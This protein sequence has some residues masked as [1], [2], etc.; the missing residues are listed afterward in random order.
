[1]LKNLALSIG[2]F[3]FCLVILEGV[4][5]FLYEE[6]WTGGQCLNC[7]HNHRD[8]TYGFV[9]PTNR[10]MEAKRVCD[11]GKVCYDVKYTY[12][13]FGRRIVG[14]EPKETS[15]MI[16]F[17]SSFAFNE[18]LPDQETFPFHVQEKTGKRVYNYGFSGSGIPY[19][20]TLL[21]TGRLQREMSDRNQDA[22]FVIGDHLLYR[23]YFSSHQPYIWGH[24]YFDIENDKV[25]SRGIM[26]E[27][28]KREIKIASLFNLLKKH[29]YF[30]KYI[31][32]AYPR[33]SK[34]VLFEK[35]LKLM[36]ETKKEYEK[37]FNG[38]FV[39]LFHTKE[40][41]T[42]FVIAMKDENLP[43]LYY[44]NDK[45]RWSKSDLC[46]CDKHPNAE[47]TKFMGEKFSED[48]LRHAK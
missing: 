42:D 46:A 17:G 34:E 36:L 35:F 38:R 47:V 7:W 4:S 43:F 28:F 23:N 37:H 32:F 16:L 22:F 40:S 13:E 39:L 5:F 24:P 6:K 11:S 8:S 15:G 2:T 26:N 25:I 1:M 33:R 48:V 3:V 29:S 45:L 44:H 18:G 21:K 20:L 41:A 14:N 30:L 19:V 31:N 9:P 10:T 12:D 27:Y